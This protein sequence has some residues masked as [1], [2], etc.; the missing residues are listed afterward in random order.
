MVKGDLLFKDRTA[1]YLM[2]VGKHLV[3]SN[4]QY[5]ANLPPSWYTLSILAQLSE[6]QFLKQLK[7]GAIHPES[8]AACYAFRLKPLSACKGFPQI[9]RMR[10][11][12]RHFKIEP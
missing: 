1:D 6:R 10:V 3:I 11:L 4:S 5:T 12:S 9:T 8:V 2:L 7:A